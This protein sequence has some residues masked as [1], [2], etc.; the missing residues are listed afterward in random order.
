[1]DPVIVP[2]L[3]TYLFKMFVLFVVTPAALYGLY[4]SQEI[5]HS[6][7][8]WYSAGLTTLVISYLVE[9]RT[10]TT[11]NDY[12]SIIGVLFILVGVFIQ[13]VRR[14]AIEDYKKLKSRREN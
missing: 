10:E 2:F 7:Y 4:K 3:E 14:M 1:M 8:V 5:W 12:Y 11:L 6:P 9:L 13:G